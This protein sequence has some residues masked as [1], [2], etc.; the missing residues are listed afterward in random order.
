MSDLLFFFNLNINFIFSVYQEKS[1]NQA[2]PGT[3]N[4]KRELS[5]V[6]TK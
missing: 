2:I 3:A 4:Q 5:L 6:G 1:K